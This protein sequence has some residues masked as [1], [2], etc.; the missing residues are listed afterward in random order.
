MADA[1]RASGRYD[2]RMLLPR[3]VGAG[4]TLPAPLNVFYATAPSGRRRPPG[5]PAAPL[6]LDFYALCDGGQMG[7]VEWLPRQRLKPETLDWVSQLDGGAEEGWGP[8]VMGRHLV[9]AYTDVG[10]VVWDAE[11]D[12]V[13]AYQNGACSW[14]LYEQTLEEFLEELFNW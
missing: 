11:A 12:Q 3:L 14:E 8:L 10:P 13:A 1:A 2:W 4:R 7:F 6:L 5:L 9:F